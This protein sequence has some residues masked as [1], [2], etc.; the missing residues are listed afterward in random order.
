MKKNK[1]IIE[2]QALGPYSQSYTAN[3]FIFCSGQIGIDPETKLLAEGIVS[4]THQVMKNLQAV[5]QEAGSD[6]NAVVKTTI[7][8]KNVEDFFK[9]NEIYAHYFGDHKPARATVGVAD[10][11]RGKFVKSPLIEIEA[12]AEVTK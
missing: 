3:G 7:Y 5:L 4:Q 6:L 10:L 9:V 8:L 12:V 2:P 1:K 11:P